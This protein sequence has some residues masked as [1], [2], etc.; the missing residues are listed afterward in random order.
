MV[1]LTFTS[2]N[3]KLEA[4]TK[5]YLISKVTKHKKL[6]EKATGITAVF[7]SSAAHKGIAQDF[8]VE[9]SVIMPLAFIK[10]EESGGNLN[11]M[12][13][14]MEVNLKRRLNRYREHFHRWERKTPWKAQEINETLTQTD[15]LE[16]P[17]PD[18][19][20]MP[21]IRRKLIENERPMHPAEAV[22]QMELLGH[23]CFLFKNIE[24]GKY[25]MIHKL[26]NSYELIEP[27]LGK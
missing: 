17:V 27:K 24:N 10:V 14:N 15:E 2:R 3:F 4:K 12:I 5:D 13:D 25:A 23:A 22:E 21:R 26:H 16:A 19:D 1:D 6:L 8:R 9:L 20:Y 18:T 11:E 7:E